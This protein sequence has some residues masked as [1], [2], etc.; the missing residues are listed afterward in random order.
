MADCFWSLGRPEIQGHRICGALSVENSRAAV[1]AAAA[2]RHVTSV[3]FDVRQTRC[4]TLVVAH[5]P[6]FNE[7]LRVEEMSYDE[8]CS[9][10]RLSNGETVPLF[11]EIVD[12]C[13]THGLRMNVEI[14]PECSYEVVVKVLNVLSSFKRDVCFSSSSSV[15]STCASV[16][17][18]SSD[19]LINPALAL[20]NISSFSLSILKQVRELA[21]SIPL[22]LLVNDTISILPCGRP[23]R[24]EIPDNPAGL[25]RSLGKSVC[26][27]SVNMCSESISAEIVENLHASGIKVLVWFASDSPKEFSDTIEDNIRAI[28]K[29]GA[30]V[31]CTNRPDLVHLE[32][33]RISE[34]FCTPVIS[35][36]SICR[37]QTAL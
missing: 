29:F 24:A 35:A 32:I 4:G 28:L 20:T 8:A 16:S 6:E 7:G 19:V 27:D 14:K 12:L 34:F 22:G 36:G 31:I 11:I 21:P 9:D 15:A 33:C 25:L 30:D 10:L 2:L 37:F 23:L 13:V 5:G 18:D 26:G 17:E 3:E 1:R